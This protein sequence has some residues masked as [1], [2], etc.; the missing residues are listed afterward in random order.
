V[1]DQPLIKVILLVGVVAVTI[2]LTRSTTGAR[3]Q[4]IRR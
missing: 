4:A 3:H 2:M 1:L